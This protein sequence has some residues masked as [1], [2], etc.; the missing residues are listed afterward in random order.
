MKNIITLM[1]VVVVLVFL[2]AGSYAERSSGQNPDEMKVSAETASKS[3]GQAMEYQASQI[4]GKG[5]QNYEGKIVGVIRDLMIDPRN[6]GIALAIFS[7]GGFL[8]IPMKFVAVPFR[9]LTFDPDKKVYLLDV[10]REEIAEAP[11][12]ERGQWPQQANRAWETE[13]YRYYGQTPEWGEAE[14]TM[15]AGHG[16]FYRFKEMRGTTVR[17]PQGERVGSIRDLVIDSEGHVSAAV[18]AQGGLLGIGAR[19]VAVSLNSL[20]FDPA[21]ESFVLH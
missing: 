2:P 8:G 15:A 7:P 6:S 21:T 16:E 14:E 20:R 11:G 9:A 10:S 1:A 12:F 18:I 4:M 17:K 19:R 13:V 5:I 3:L